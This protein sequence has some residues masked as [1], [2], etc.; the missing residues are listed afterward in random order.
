MAR[1]AKVMATAMRVA[2]DKKGNGK[3]RKGY[4]N[5]DK[6]CRSK[7]VRTIRIF[8]DGKRSI[9]GNAV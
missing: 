8:K 9:Y 4:G 6:V 1:A 2:G 7:I 3:G 5:G